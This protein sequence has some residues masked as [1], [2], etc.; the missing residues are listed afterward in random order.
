MSTRYMQ[1][2]LV[3]MSSHHKHHYLIQKSTSNRFILTHRYLPNTATKLWKDSVDGKTT[4]T[5]AIKEERRNLFKDRVF[6]FI[7]SKLVG[8]SRLTNQ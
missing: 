1:E 8:L 6:V 3:E 7:D 5:L 4:P 2:W